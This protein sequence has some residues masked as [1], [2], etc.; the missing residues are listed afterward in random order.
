[1]WMRIPLSQEDPEG[2]YRF[3]NDVQEAFLMALVAAGRPSDAFMYMGDHIRGDDALYFTPPAVQVFEGTIRAQGG[4]TCD[5]PD[6]GSL[7]LLVKA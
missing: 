7:S 2:S 6:I 4:E 5:A 1:M 3:I